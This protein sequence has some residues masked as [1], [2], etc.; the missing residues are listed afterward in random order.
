[1]PALAWCILFVAVMLVG[2]VM[3]YLYDY[4]FGLVLAVTGLVLALV[5]GV[6]FLEERACE[7]LGER[8]GLES[9]LGAVELE[10]YLLE[11]DGRWRPADTYRV[12]EDR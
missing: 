6:V 3:F 5:S 4:G 10:C 11:P 9:E 12:G 8:Y 2:A 1:M 7:R